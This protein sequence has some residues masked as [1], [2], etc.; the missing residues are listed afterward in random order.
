M[1]ILEITLQGHLLVAGGQAAESGADLATARCRYGGKLVP[2][3]PATALR[4][5]VRIQLEAL[6]KGGGLDREVVEPYP[7][8]VP[9][10]QVPPDPEGSVARLFGYSG[11]TG[12]R[13]GAGEGALRFS[14]AIPIDLARA[15]AALRVRPG[16]ELEN[17]TATA[18][19]K[20]LFFREVAEVSSEPLVFRAHLTVVEP[21]KL[22]TGDLDFL[23][24]A[25][26]ITDS[27]GAGKA[28]GGGEVTV[29]WIDIDLPTV[30]RVQGDSASGTRARLLFTL[31]EPAHFGDGGPYANH[32]ATRTYIPGATVRGAVAWSLLRN[33]RTQPGDKGF[34]ELF[35]EGPPAS[36]GDALLVHEADAEPS[37]YSATARTVRGSKHD[38]RNV[39]VPELA[40]ERV[41]R[42]GAES[43]VYIRT[44]DGHERLDPVE[45][46]RPSDR[47]VR[48]TRTRVSIDRWKGTAAEGRLFSIEQLDPIL[49]S[50]NVEDVHPARFVSWVEGLTPAAAHSL[51]GLSGTA[52]LV[53]AGR[54]HG[55]GL[56]EVDV[57][58]ESEPH[59]GEPEQ[60]VRELARLIDRAAADLFRRAGI[61]EVSPSTRKLPLALVA[62]SDYVPSRADIFDPLSEPELKTL[63]LGFRGLGRKFLKAGVSGGYDQRPETAAA[64]KD[65]LPAVGAGSVFVYEIDPD[66]LGETLRRLLPPLRRGVGQRVDSGCG[67]FGLLELET[68][69]E[70]KM[71]PQT[72][73]DLKSWM[74]E[75]A[76]AILNRVKGER[77][78]K[79]ATSQLR[80][81]LQIT[82]QESEIPVLE[83]FLN[84]QRGRRATRDFWKL[85]H[86][87][88]VGALKEIEKRTTGQG[89]ETRRIAIQQFFGYLVRHYIYLDQLNLESRSQNRPPERAAR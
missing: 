66:E 64:L 11:P 82:Q 31:V 21:P 18:E 72:G 69:K 49:S 3:I 42:A 53:G 44:D 32:H 83:N 33:G 36:F 1:P 17:F 52:V 26:E 38:L 87:P 46:A 50:K 5:A 65:L 20:K 28:K 12:K 55:L 89:A 61:G 40:R 62:L 57:R 78:F 76:E 35:L 58:F 67:R 56:V 80:N 8:D 23:R 84:Y 74:V 7:F 88:V 34:K 54:K 75:Q 13:K 70:I 77:D 85:I 47:L 39:L 19:D 59:E 63:D 37:L 2:Y 14:D 29:R 30:V 60:K 25:V 6:L 73:P 45:E 79:G 68:P 9:E 27:I 81:L 4:G 51:A 16:V 43:A 41:N 71:N 10:G 86:E 15:E 24:A 48:H 22:K